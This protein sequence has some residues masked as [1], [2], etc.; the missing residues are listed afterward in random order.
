[1]LGPLEVVAGTL[2]QHPPIRNSQRHH[3]RHGKHRQVELKKI[4]SPSRAKAHP[5]SRS[6]KA[7]RR[8]DR[9][10]NLTGQRPH[11]HTP[12][13]S[14]RSQP[15][16]SEPLPVTP[17]CIT[18]AKFSAPDNGA[19]D[20]GAPLALSLNDLPKRSL[21]CR[22]TLYRPGGERLAAVDCASDI[23][24][25]CRLHVPLTSSERQVL[26][27]GVREVCQHVII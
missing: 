6:R 25:G 10:A 5:A 2:F 16:H 22:C 12:P 9:I 21:R 14:R 8:A 3:L 1:M 11:P 24:T 27:L 7:S 13:I 18:H 26:C 20:N 17:S 15:A 4:R 19:P 23:L